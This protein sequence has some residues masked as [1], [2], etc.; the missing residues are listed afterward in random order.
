MVVGSGFE[1][2]MLYAGGLKP[3]AFTYLANPPCNAPSEG[4]EPPNDAFNALGLDGNE[5]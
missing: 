1:P 4:L 3:P 2:L 5:G